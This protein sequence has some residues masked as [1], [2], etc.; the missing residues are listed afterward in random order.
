[1]LAF[2]ND[3][4]PTARGI[5]RCY[6]AENFSPSTIHAW[7]GHLKEAKG[8]LVVS[9]SAIVAVTGMT[10]TVNPDHTTKVHRYVLSARQPGVLWIPAGYANGR[11]A[12]EPNTKMMFFSTT[13]LEESSGDD[14]RFRWNYW[15][16]EVW[17][18]ENR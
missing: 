6:V 9:G 12:L 18:V 3:F 7:H 11:R 13:T 16:P 8:V 10:D 5:K 14:Y 17:Q 1:M 2:V 15:G 4:N